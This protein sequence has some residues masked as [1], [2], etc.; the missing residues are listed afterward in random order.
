M[1]ETT[2]I[3]GEAAEAVGRFQRCAARCATSWA[4]R[5]ATVGARARVRV[6]VRAGAGAGAGARARARAGA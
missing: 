6:R 1:L 5:L 2:S 4:L 3:R